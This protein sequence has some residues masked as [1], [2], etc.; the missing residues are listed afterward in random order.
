[1]DVVL[2]AVGVVILELGGF[3]WDTGRDTHKIVS[4]P[5]STRR[6]GG[7]KLE[8]GAALRLVPYKGVELVVVVVVDAILRIAS[9][10][11]LL[12]SSLGSTSVPLAVRWPKV[13]ALAVLGIKSVVARGGAATNAKGFCCC[14]SGEVG[15]GFFARSFLLCRLGFGWGEYVVLL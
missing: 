5:S 13:Q 11:V 7:S 1:M 14:D 2:L 15:T 8:P 4:S 6:P 10:A 12:W 9:L 3:W